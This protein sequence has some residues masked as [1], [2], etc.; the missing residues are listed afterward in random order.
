MEKN[1]K[2]LY[3]ESTII[4]NTAIAI[5]LAKKIGLSEEEIKEGLKDIKISSMRFEE[6][7]VGED[8]YINDAYNASPT[9]RRQQQTL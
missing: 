2:C 3:Q 8:I 7:R 1:M 5:E 6:I 9:S 4:S